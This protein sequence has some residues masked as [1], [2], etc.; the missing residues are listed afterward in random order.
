M[1][2]NLLMLSILAMPFAANAACN[3]LDAA[4]S[5]KAYIAKYHPQATNLKVGARVDT[6]NSLSRTRS[7]F[8][9]REGQFD[10]VGFV[11]F[12]PNAATC[13]IVRSDSDLVEFG[14]N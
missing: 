8:S 7:G 5:V 11:S 2:M 10:M 9:Y 12:D 13:E 4:A 1:K 14:V 3:D 6:L